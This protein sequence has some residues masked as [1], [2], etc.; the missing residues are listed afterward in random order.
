M[1]ARPNQLFPNYPDAYLLPIIRRRG[2]GEKDT[3]KKKKR[4][5]EQALS[6]MVP[7]GMSAASR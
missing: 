3:K 2:V 6:F 4:E 5:S 7:R 1:Q